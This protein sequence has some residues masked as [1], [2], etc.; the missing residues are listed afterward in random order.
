[1]HGMSIDTGDPAVRYRIGGRTLDEQGRAGR[2]VGGNGAVEDIVKG[3][4]GVKRDADAERV[5][6]VA[7]RHR[8]SRRP[9]ELH[10]VGGA[11]EA[12]HRALAD[13]IEVRLVQVD[14]AAQG[15]THKAGG[16][17]VGRGAGKI[18]AEIAG[19]VGVRH[20]ALIHAVEPALQPQAMGVLHHDGGILHRAAA[21]KQDAGQGYFSAGDNADAGDDQIGGRRNNAVRDFIYRRDNYSLYRHAVIKYPESRGGRGRRADN[22]GGAGVGRVSHYEQPVA[23]GRYTLHGHL[24]AVSLRIAYHHAGGGA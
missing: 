15:I 8:I 12:R 14:R 18:Q 11:C 24:L 7:V 13:L 4:Q 19:A 23:V 3:R 17:G 6:D 2:S 22:R 1:M 16:Y 10:N 5:I 20:G 9:V 21:G